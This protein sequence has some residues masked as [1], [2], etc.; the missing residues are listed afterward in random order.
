[1][2]ILISAAHNLNLKYPWLLDKNGFKDMYAI[3]CGE[4]IITGIIHY[5]LT[6][7]EG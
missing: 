6:L 4:T 2:T 7:N 5:C 1:M 3:S